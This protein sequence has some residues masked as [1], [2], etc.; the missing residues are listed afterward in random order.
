M[1]TGH[2]QEVVGQSPKREE[3]PAHIPNPR[4]PSRFSQWCE[5]FFFLN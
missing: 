2:V 4:N 1:I 5:T 3:D